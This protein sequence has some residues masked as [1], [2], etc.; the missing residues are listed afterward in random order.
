MDRTDFQKHIDELKKNGTS[1]TKAAEKVD[2]HME[3]ETNKLRA[4]AKMA[5]EICFRHAQA[6]RETEMLREEII[7]GTSAGEDW[8]TLFYKAVKIVGLATGDTGF[9][10]IVEGAA[11]RRKEKMQ[12]M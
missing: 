4:E 7:K 9:L 6:T 5:R 12:D 8:E 10:P 3:R 11:R 1:A 2:G